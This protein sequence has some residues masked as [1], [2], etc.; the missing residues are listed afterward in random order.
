MSDT[1]LFGQNVVPTCSSAP[2]L[3][4]VNNQVRNLK[5][6]LRCDG[7]H[8]NALYSYRGN[9]V[10]VRAHPPPT[11]W[12]WISFT[13]LTVPWLLHRINYALLKGLR[14]PVGPENNINLP[15]FMNHDQKKKIWDDMTSSNSIWVNFVNTYNYESRV[16]LGC[17]FSRLLPFTQNFLRPSTSVPYWHLE[18]WTSWNLQ[19]LGET[20]QG[21]EMILA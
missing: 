20:Q 16:S 19:V 3:R 9:P 10:N 12:I 7:T 2:P 21:N 4:G 13:Q 6:I 14:L 15:P 18:R 17:R 8:C 1:T 11:P 5:Y